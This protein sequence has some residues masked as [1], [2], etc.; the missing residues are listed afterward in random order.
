MGYN[1]HVFTFEVQTA[2]YVVFGNERR[3]LAWDRNDGLRELP[4]P[5]AE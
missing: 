2:S 3:V 1:H 4:F 5:E